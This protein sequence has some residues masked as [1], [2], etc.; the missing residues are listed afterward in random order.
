MTSKAP[1]LREVLIWTLLAVG[2]LQMA[3]DLCG[4]RFIKGLGAATAASPFPKVFCDAKGL[5]PFASTFTLVAETA[6]GRITELQIT[7]EVY[8]RL[9]GPYNRRNVYG[10]ALS[11]APR[12][13]EPLWK[14]IASYGLRDGGP[15]Q[16]EFGLPKNAK[17]M[18]I[19]IKTNTR[20]RDN[21]WR[22]ELP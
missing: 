21:I 3:G 14:A 19:V 4:S 5:E 8:A 13:P 1:L 10:A 22:F 2:L 15:L 9:T 6:G 20:G 17:R 18:T 11:Y 7:P 12:L 16:Q